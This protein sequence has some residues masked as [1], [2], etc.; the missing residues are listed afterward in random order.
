[1]VVAFLPFPTRLFG[2]YTGEAEPERVPSRSTA[3]ICWRVLPVLA[4]LGYLA[5]AVHIIVPI[6]A[7]RRRASAA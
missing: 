4:V 1:M 6:P 2:E 5:I 7:V 3:S